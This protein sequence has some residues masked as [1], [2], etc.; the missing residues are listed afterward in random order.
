MTDLLDQEINEFALDFEEPLEEGIFKPRKMT[1]ED[2]SMRLHER[3]SLPV[4]YKKVLGI[5]SATYCALVCTK[6][7][8]PGQYLITVQRGEHE[9]DEMGF[10]GRPNGSIVFACK[11]FDQLWNYILE[12]ISKLPDNYTPAYTFIN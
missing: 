11:T 3:R 10:S 4:Y 1:R 8:V 7:G 6:S 5:P 9:R 12:T 2:F